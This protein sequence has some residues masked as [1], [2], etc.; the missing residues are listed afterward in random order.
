MET[1]VQLPY[2]QESPPDSLDV[3][4]EGKAD[5]RLWKDWMVSFVGSTTRAAEDVEPTAFVDL[6]GNQIR[7]VRMPPRE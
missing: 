7:A 6:V 1:L 2:M 3:V 5:S 4:F